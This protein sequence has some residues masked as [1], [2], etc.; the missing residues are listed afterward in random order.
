MGRTKETSDES[1]DTLSVSDIHKK[2]ITA[3]IL[4]FGP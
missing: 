4:M 3:S 1:T 2:L